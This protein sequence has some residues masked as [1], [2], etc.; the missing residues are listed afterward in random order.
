[1]RQVAFC[2]GCVE[3]GQAPPPPPPPLNVATALQQQQ[4]PPLDLL[5]SSLDPLTDRLRRDTAAVAARWGGG[6]GGGSEGW[7]PWTP[8]SR[9]V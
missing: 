8:N 3:R 2:R 1:M 9:A 7:G 5:L 6:V 4:Q